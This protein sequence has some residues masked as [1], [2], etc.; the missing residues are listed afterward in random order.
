MPVIL[1]AKN[2]DPWLSPAELGAEKTVPLFKPYPASQMKAAAV[3]TQVDNPAFDSIE[4][5]RRL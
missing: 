2:Y 4:C 3:S 1:A 5:V